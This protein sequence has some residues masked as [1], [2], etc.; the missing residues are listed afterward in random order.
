MNV[1]L[2]LLVSRTAPAGTEI[3]SS[4]NSNYVHPMSAL[5]PL[6]ISWLDI[7][8]TSKCHAVGQHKNGTLRVVTKNLLKFT[9]PLCTYTYLYIPHNLAVRRI[10]EKK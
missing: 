5:K 2:K 7:E 1:G 6:L 3:L 8:Q 9:K 4:D 10:F